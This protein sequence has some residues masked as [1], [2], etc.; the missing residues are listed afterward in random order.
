MG[1]I[2]FLAHRVPFPP[3]RGDKIRAFH[4]LRHLSASRRVHLAAFAD[5]VEDMAPGT[6]LTDL[7]GESHVQWRAKSHARAMAEAVLTGDAASVRAFS[8]AAMGSAVA[9]L[10][11]RHPIDTIYVFSSQMAQYL[12]ADRRFRV[13]M[14]FVDVDS[15]K[16][17]EYAE[18][19]RAP[20]NWLY[21]REGRMLLAHD[22]RVAERADA[23]LFVSEVEAAVFRDLTGAPRV[24][25]VENGIDTVH[26]DPAAA[27][28]RVP[29]AGLAIVFTG[30]M[31]YAP[32]IEGARWLV[33]DILPMVRRRH[34]AACVAIVG[35]NPTAPVIALAQVG[36]VTVTGE[37][38]DVRGWLAAADVVAAPLLQARGIQNKV[39]EAMAMACPLVASGPAA[40]G[41]DHG[42]TIRVVDDTAAIAGAIADLLDDR[43]AAAKLGVAA[44]AQ[45]VR[46]YGWDARLAVLDA[47]LGFGPAAG[48]AAA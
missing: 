23:S 16:F 32:N 40:E 10:I 20:L 14:D 44:R 29:L 15:A 26:F 2:L 28:E 37:V 41:V 38:P 5:T 3:N 4:I 9:G 13:M 34:P 47:L 43:V 42:G 25:A 7:L 6:G 35:R 21:A 27:F 12:P 22:R 30:Q 45:V 1:D 24:H 31:D 8:D 17:A 11:A 48:R 18:T 19:A 33:R 46:R 39:L 36:G